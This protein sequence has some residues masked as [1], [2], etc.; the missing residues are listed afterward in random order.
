[1][2]PSKYIL[3]PP[4]DLHPLAAKSA[5]SQNVYPDF[6][7][8]AHNEVEDKILLSF[9]A[10]G[11]YNSA[12]VNFES[13]SAR[14]SLQESLPKVADM[15]AEQFSKVVNLREQTIN[16]VSSVPD[17]SIG[18][19]PR[20]TDLAGPGF[21]LPNRVTLTD[22]RKSQWL[23]E[24]SSPNVS[25]FKLCRSIPHG[26]KRKQILEQC[27]LRQIPLQRAI[28]LIKSSYSMEWKSLMSKLKPGQI[29]KTIISQLYNLWTNNM[30]SIMERL[31]FEMPKYYNDNAQLKVWKLRVSYYINLLGNCYSMGL[32]DKAVFNHWLVEFVEK[33][34]NFEFL[35]LT[36]H[37]LNVFW[38]GIC[39]L[40]ND[41]DS[42]NDTFLIS[43]ITSVL[44]QKYHIVSQ[45][46]SMINDEN[47]IINDLQRNAKL[48]ENILFR[49]KSYILDIFH[50]QSL[51][52]FIMPNQNWDTYKNC[53]YEII[54][55]EKIV[56][57]QYTVI[58]RK[59]ELITYRNDS[60]K[61]N[62]FIQCPKGSPLLCDSESS[63]DYN[64]KYDLHS[65]LNV[66]FLDYEMTAILDNVAPGYDWS[67]FVQQK[68]TCIKQVNQM[69]LWACHPSRKARYD[70][71]HLV[72]KLLLL[73]ANCQENP[74][75]YSNI[76]DKIWSLVFHF[77]KLN[78]A[79]LT[80]I[81]NLT[82]LYGLLNIFISYGIIK[83]PTYIR[84]LISSGIMYI[85]DSKDKFFHC[86]LLINLKISPLMKNQYNMVLKNIMEYDPTYFMQFSYEKLQLLLAAVKEE[87]LQDNFENLSSLPTSV[88]IWVSEWYLS[89]V[90][91][92]F[93]GTLKQVDKA[94]VIKNFTIFGIQL[95][96]IFHFYKWVEFIVYHQLLS[97]MDSLGSLI[98]ILLC[99]ENLFPILINDQ[100]LFIKTILHIYSKELRFKD[101]ILYELIELNPFWKFFMKSFPYLV[102]IDSDL[103]LQLGEV[104]ESERNR[105]ERLMKSNSDV[106]TLYCDI[107]DIKGESSSKFGIHNFPSIFQQNLKILLKS[108]DEDTGDKARK[109][110][111]L[112]MFANIGDYNK[113]MSIFLKRKDFSTKQLIKLISLKLLTLDLVHKVIGD[114]FLSDIIIHKEYNYGLWFELHKKTFIKKNFKLVASLYQNSDDIEEHKFFI[115][116]LVEYG[117]Y[118]KLQEQVTNIICNYL[119]EHRRDYSLIVELLKYG[120]PEGLLEPIKCVNPT[121]LYRQLNFT[122]VWIFQALTKYYTE[123]LLNNDLNDGQTMSNFV[124]DI[125][126]LTQYDVTCSHVF[127][128]VTQVDVIEKL[129]QVVEADFF[130]KCLSDE[131]DDVQFLAV[132][133]ET[134]MKLSRKV[135]Q[136][137]GGITMTEK[138]FQLLQR[139]MVKF[140]Q[141]DKEA[142]SNAEMKLNIY[143]KIFTVHQKFIFQKICDTLRNS[144][145]SD[146]SN[147]VTALRE[148]FENTGFNLKLKLLL[149]DILSSLKSFVIYESTKKGEYTLDQ[150]KIQ[151]PEELHNLPPF[152]ISS[153]LD[154][155][156][157]TTMNDFSLL[158]LVEHQVQSEGEETSHFFIYN[159]ETK[160]YE[161]SLYV[162]PFQL[163]MNHQNREP[164]MN[165]HCFNDTALSLSLFDARF[166]KKNPT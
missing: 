159:K 61:F 127:D 105:V 81:L 58:K 90:C 164:S 138:S 116:L 128:M 166:D 122:S 101:K 109:G 131:P 13:I 130:Q 40:T 135:T 56:G 94:T 87:M 110:L 29:N 62:S 67:L 125:I 96:E 93:D 137:N 145:N 113:F 7:P 51:E 54:A 150:R 20:F 156:P 136:G 129:L 4:E 86:E 120:V 118:S 18:G 73:K 146:G 16:K 2:P 133:I 151:V 100:I 134:I 158:G 114:E 9:V 25:L 44:L 95:N 115:D 157:S 17:K 161:C 3:T 78:E 155:H 30:V 34:E 74:Q 8:W 89:Y 15:L 21:S 112:L 22:Q 98:D 107:N 12:K 48:K 119:K 153:F 5:N 52:A 149:Y 85:P 70:G 6:D 35:P 102:E 10:K 152:H 45:S 24:L 64:S 53:L 140:R 43:K 55:L 91:S 26:F 163:L 97:D 121:E 63:M 108:V 38:C 88:K 117:T 162:E 66:Q 147:L 46:K 59:M 106:V 123:A 154:E 36:L 69:I 143:L 31:V 1:M 42:S 33:V 65:L 160:E 19:K 104:Y 141:M 72:A 83:V 60:L 148:L 49:I 47:Y 92:S 76:E 71:P 99:Y 77:S 80:N 111:L 41:L 126:D 79:D 132:M 23:Q 11:H 75:E 27:Y 57:E 82:S 84:K 32:M 124:F 165:G 37:L 50:N 142:L 14:S 139:S 68:F 103:Q 144:I 28:W 39:P